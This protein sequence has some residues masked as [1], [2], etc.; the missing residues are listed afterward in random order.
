MAGEPVGV[1]QFIDTDTVDIEINSEVQI[2]AEEA[3]PG[4]THQPESDL[5]SE[6]SSGRRGRGRGGRGNKPVFSNH[7][8]GVFGLRK[9]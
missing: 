3:V 8:H 6:I 5:K 9:G 1:S 2:S 7:R 4:H